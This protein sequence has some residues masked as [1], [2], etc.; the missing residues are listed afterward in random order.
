MGQPRGWRPL[1]PLLAHRVVRS[2]AVTT[3]ALPRGTDN[4]LSG[5]SQPPAQKVIKNLPQSR[6]PKPPTNDFSSEI[7]L[8]SPRRSS[9]QSV[10]KSAARFVA[11]G[12]QIR[13][14]TRSARPGCSHTHI[15]SLSLPCALPAGRRLAEPPP[16]LPLLP[17][18]GA[19]RDG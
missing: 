3:P 16:Q 17:G 15:L 8:Q 13:L 14:G 2:G 11:S 6:L 12:D 4:N 19:L 1:S 10:E 18:D 7:N 5:G 9:R